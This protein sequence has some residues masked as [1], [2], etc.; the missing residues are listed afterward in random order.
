MRFSRKSL[1]PAV[2]E[3]RVN[4]HPQINL[5]IV[6]ARPSEESDI[7][8][9]TIQR[10]LIESLDRASARVNSHILRPGTFESL[11]KHLQEK[12]P[13]YYHI[14]H[15]D[16]HGAVLSYE[17][18]LQS[19]E[20]AEVIF[21]YAHSFDRASHS[22][23]IRWGRGNLDEYEGKKAFLLFESE[24][25]G[26]A[27]PAEAKEIA[28]LLQ[29]YRLPVCIINACQSAK[30]DG[31][32]ND[33]SLAKHLQEQ[34]VDLVLAMR[35]SVSVSAA[36]KFMQC[37]YNT[38]FENRPIEEAVAWS[39]SLLFK[40][41]NREAYLGYSIE[42]EDWVLPIVYQRKPVKFQIRAFD[43]TEEEAYFAKRSRTS[44]FSTPRYG[45]YGRD[46]DILKIEKLLTKHNHLL[47]TGMIG[48][49]KSALLRYLSDWWIRTNFKAVRNVIYFDWKKS[50]KETENSSAPITVLTNF[51]AKAAFPEGE[52]ESWK[53]KKE[54][55]RVHSLIEYLN[56]HSHG[57]ILDHIF[58]LENQDALQFLQRIVGKSFVVYSSVNPELRLS[59]YTFKQAVYRLGGLDK[60]ASY[61]L[62][63]AIVKDTADKDLDKLL[64]SFAQ[65]YEFKQLQELIQGFPGTMQ[66][67]LPLLKDRSLETLGEQFREGVLPG[68][69]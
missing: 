63:E 19:K 36:T 61:Q 34:G 22:Y 50:I 54:S 69:S 25:K 6:T 59:E 64:D 2:L 41:K 15:F 7:S 21:S 49:G 53:T 10:P 43:S 23:Q 26:R 40:D 20:K 37:F 1:R 30:Q 60:E 44:Q 68:Y 18:L 12:K 38:L 3:A 24:E 57:I 39:R 5:L 28:A 33:T 13:G 51:L 14:I 47:I 67:V 56:A 45:F 42:L 52:F 11:S 58:T 32:A 9:R 31:T 65:R 29:Q 35:Y 17:E 8:Y 27:E 66:E 55:V 46:L 48:A 4:D 16:L 62:A